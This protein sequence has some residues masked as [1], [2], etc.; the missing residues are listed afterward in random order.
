MP[1]SV[2]VARVPVM[3]HAILAG[4]ALFT[5]SS[6][7][8]QSA[9]LVPLV[10]TNASWSLFKGRTEASSPDITAWRTNGFNDSAFTNTPAP[11]TYGE[12]YAYGTVLDDMINQYSCFFLRRTFVITN[13]S[14]F[15]ALQFGAK[16]DDGFVAW[17]NGVEVARTNI[18]SPGDPVVFTSLAAG[19]TEPVPF[20]FYSL[21]P[22]NYLVLGTNTLA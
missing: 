16:V 14:Q 3:T 2:P 9:A 6:V 12:S 1:E 8:L 5:A 15:S 18:G 21:Y 19:A 13:L 11:F 22:P 7:L 4:L 17:I 10:A 20:Q